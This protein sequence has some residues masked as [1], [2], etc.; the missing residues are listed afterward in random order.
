VRVSLAVLAF[1]VL[2]SACNGR[3]RLTCERP[4]RNLPTPRGGILWFGEMHGTEESP[5]F[6]GDVA[7]TVAR[8]DRVQLGLEIPQLEQ[9]RINS[10]LMNGDRK[11]LL[12]GAFWKGQDGRAS[13]AM[14]A[15]LD[16]IRDL[17][18]RGAKIE[19]VTYD[20]TDELDRDLAMANA[21]LAARDEGATWIGLSGNVHS[22]KTPYPGMPGKP[23]VAHLVDKKL[24]ITT[25]DVSATG[26][27][28]WACVS[29]DGVDAGCGVHPNGNDGGKGK[30]WTLGPANDPSHD[31]VY[32]VG[33]TK[34]SMPVQPPT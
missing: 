30:P 6:V 12:E 25:Y 10:Y 3:K 31:G 7:C 19:V 21:V 4:V 9:L 33:E 11:A 14:V 2:L 15:L 5:K 32:F 18:L 23:L 27:T 34:A 17:R 16:R 22:R 26:G 29:K 20:I 1:A 8:Y 13:N 24:P 28:M